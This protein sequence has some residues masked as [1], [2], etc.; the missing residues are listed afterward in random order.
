MSLRTRLLGMLGL[1][2]LLLGGT[3]MIWMYHRAADQLDGALDSRLAASASMVARLVAQWPQA[4]VGVT[5]DEPQAI[6]VLARD[7]VACEVSQWRAEVLARTL[8][9][10][11]GSPKLQAAHNGLGYL[12]QKGVR[13]RTYVLEQG[14]LRIATADRMDLRDGLK[15]EVAL[16]AL[17][18]FGVCLLVGLGLLWLGVARG[19]APLER[20]RRLLTADVPLQR[21]D[22]SQAR[23]PQELQPFT[24]TIDELLQRMRLALQRERRFAD[25][26]AH[27]IRTPLTVVKTHL[28]ILQ[29]LMPAQASAACRTSLDSALL[30]A[31]RLRRLVDQLLA[32]TRIEHAP[33]QAPDGSVSGDAPEH[34]PPDTDLAATLRLAFEGLPQ[35]R[36]RLHMPEHAVRVAVPAALLASALRNLVDNALKYSPAT[37][38][39]AVEVDTAQVEIRVSDQGPG[40]DE[41]ALRLALE[42]FWRGG[43]QVEGSGL[44]LAIVAAIARRFQGRL[45]LDNQPSGGLCCRLTLPCVR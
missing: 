26:A 27:E 2:W 24:R 7:G 20:V 4:P 40:M 16:T 44:G 14:N 36:L 43:Q 15:R 8:A 41:A 18:P 30:G 13:W 33:A 17:L 21:L 12:E 23:V 45:V 37:V 42:P 38:D 10:T 25:N 9:R 32:L 34:A 31:D 19:L 28:Q 3:M 1:T 6:D 5:P 22:V 29:R 35:S 39:I 11:P